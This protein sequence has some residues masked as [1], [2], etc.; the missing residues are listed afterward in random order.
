M[1][2]NIYMMGHL[3]DFER[4]QG[5]TA[6]YLIANGIKVIDSEEY[7]LNLKATYM[8]QWRRKMLST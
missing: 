3:R 5:V 1:D 2:V 8:K 7:I 4:R 6:A